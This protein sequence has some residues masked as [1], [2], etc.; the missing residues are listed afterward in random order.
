M[1]NPRGPGAC[2]TCPLNGGC[3]DSITAEADVFAAA[4]WGYDLPDTDPNE[5][6]G[7]CCGGGCG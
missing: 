6:Q 2:G 5:P 3:G 7:P 1:I 4:I